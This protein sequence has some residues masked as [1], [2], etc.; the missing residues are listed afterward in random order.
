MNEDFKND[1][2][3]EVFLI[4]KFGCTFENIKQHEDVLRIAY[5]AFLF[6]KA[7]SCQS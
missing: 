4:D 2:E 3:F 1:P 7:I 6:G 5:D